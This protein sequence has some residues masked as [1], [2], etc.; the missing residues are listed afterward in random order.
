MIKK[1][2]VILIVTSLIGYLEW[3]GNNKMFVAEGELDIL[4]K[5]F[6]DPLSVIH[7]FTLLP[8]LGQ[9]FLL[10]TLLQKRPKKWMILTGIT[11]IGLLYLM[12][13][14]IG[15]L[16]KNLKIVIFS[17]PFLLSSAWMIRTLSRS[18][19]V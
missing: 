6:Q 11:G 17:L 18:K 3:G 13:L 19:A 8:L 12:M 2:I 15:I 7:P 16:G 4:Q 9:L 1:L 14:I 5:L 10:I